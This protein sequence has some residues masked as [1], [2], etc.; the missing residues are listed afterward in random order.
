MQS[1][2]HTIKLHTHI[3][4]DRQTDRQTDT[5]GWEQ[6]WE[7]KQEIQ[8]NQYLCNGRLVEAMLIE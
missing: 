6:S 8:I 7:H 5:N 2:C 3:Q 4:T 1:V